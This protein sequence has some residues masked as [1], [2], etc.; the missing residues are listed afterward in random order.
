TSLDE[1]GDT[2][3]ADP[4]PELEWYLDHLDRALP[5]RRHDVRAQ[6]P[7]VKATAERAVAL[8]SA[9]EKVLIFCH[10]RATGRALRQHISA[11]LNEQIVS[12]AKKKLP[13]VSAAQVQQTLEK[14]GDRFF[15]EDRLQS[16]VTEWI[17]SIVRRYPQISSAHAHDV[18]DVV[19]RFIRTPSFLVRYLPL[20]ARDLRKAFT[21]AVDTDYEGRESL[22]RK[23]EHFCQFLAQRCIEKERQG[24]LDALRSIQTGTHIGREA[25]Q[26][27]DPAEAKGMSADSSSLLPNVRLANG[28][29]RAE[30]RMR[31]LL[32]FNTPLFPEILI[33]S[34]VMA[35]GV[36]LHLNCRYVIHHDLCWNPS[37]LEQRSGRVDR[38][39]SKA[40]RAG[41]PIHLY[42]P[43]V[44][45]TQDEKMFRV[46]QDRE[47]W[48]QVIMG[49]KYSVDEATT[50][51][52]AE[53]I[54]LPRSLQQ[55]LTMHLHPK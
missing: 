4:V 24:F 25:R 50:D 44:A 11:L 36:D 16:A 33:A 22:R 38:I 17:E 7:K 8:W 6:H 29:V 37:T 40:E 14:L 9:G 35:E 15:E 12:L 34:S 20:D 10:Y 45:A 23:I 54:L 41:R 51:R 48:F 42:M 30:T 47:R 21:E 3:S 53:R 26:V 2:A 19:R 32:A 39:G 18:V 1:D 28:E 31:L 46:V 27:F 52:E 13:R 5:R 55:E 43:Y 49:E